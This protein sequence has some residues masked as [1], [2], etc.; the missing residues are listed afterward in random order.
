MNKTCDIQVGGKGRL[1]IQTVTVLS[2]HSTIHTYS[3]LFV[4]YAALPD[5]STRRMSTVINGAIITVAMGY[6]MVGMPH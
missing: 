3:Q 4:I 6:G 2:P 1:S 5:V